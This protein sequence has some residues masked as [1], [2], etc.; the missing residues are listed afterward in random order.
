MATFLLRLQKLI[1]A[2]QEQ[3]R[4]S[5]GCKEHVH[6]KATH[7]CVLQ[8]A[9]EALVTR[10]REHPN[11]FEPEELETVRMVQRDYCDGSP[12]TPMAY[13]ARATE[14][15]EQGLFKGKAPLGSSFDHSHA[16][17][18]SQSSGKQ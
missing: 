15:A 16:Y 9:T 18:G 14:L 17:L 1:N 4:L 5:A 6:P 7:A 2:A 12:N 3:T 13:F 10:T 8:I 11:E